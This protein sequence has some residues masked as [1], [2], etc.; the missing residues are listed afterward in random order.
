MNFTSLERFLFLNAFVCGSGYS[1]PD[2]RG[3]S[4]GAEVGVFTPQMILYS[5]ASITPVRKNG[6]SSS[7]MASL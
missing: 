4:V 3:D 7:V 5:P 1:P 6:S 2:I